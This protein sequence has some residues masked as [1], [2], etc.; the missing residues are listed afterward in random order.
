MTREDFEQLVSQW[1]D[2]PER[3]D[4]RAEVERAAAASPAL[5]SLLDEW[6]RLDR[7][8]RAPEHPAAGLD[9]KLFQREISDGIGAAAPHDQLH[10][11]IRTATALDDKIDWPRLKNHF[12]RAID[13]ERAPSRI[14]GFPL[15]RFAAASAVLAAAA[16]LVL[17]ITLPPAGRAARIGVA[18]VQVF[19]PEASRIAAG[20]ADG[21]ARVSVNAA[22]TATV[23]PEGAESSRTGAAEVFLM[24]EPARF[25]ARGY[26]SFTPFGVR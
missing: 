12:S 18:R 15:G 14:A 23:S 10:R 5:K 3:Q 1:L 22:P 9:W 26:E 24:V 20:R 25:A 6:I 16:A 8:I 21:V 7:L 17:M 4:L 19:S 13:A 11:M 2:Q